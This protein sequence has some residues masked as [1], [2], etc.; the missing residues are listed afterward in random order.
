M[1]G[2]GNGQAQMYG[3]RAESQDDMAMN[4]GG[5]AFPANMVDCGRG[6]GPEW[7]QSYA[8]GGMTL[9]Q[10]YAGQALVGLIVAF[11]N[12]SEKGL[13]EWAFAQ[14]DAM[15]EQEAKDATS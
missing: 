5:P 1:A 7:P 14:A 3:G 4:D 13:A 10:Y 15:I 2:L 6:R 12:R 9:R 11:A 8:M